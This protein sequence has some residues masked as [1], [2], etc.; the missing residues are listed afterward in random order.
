MF[1]KSKNLIIA[2]FILTASLIALSIY[3]HSDGSIKSISLLPDSASIKF[4]KKGCSLGDKFACNKLGNL[5]Y[6]KGRFE[7]AVEHYTQACQLE[8]GSGCN[9][10][11]YMLEKGKGID[12]DMNNALKLYKKACKYGDMEGCHNA[13]SIY[14][15]A[16]NYYKAKQYFKMSCGENKKHKRLGASCN[17]LGYM[18]AHGIYVAYSPQRAAK[19]Y[20]DACDNLGEVS[21]CNNLAYM[22][23]NGKGFK[24]STL[25][26]DMFYMKACELGDSSSCSKTHY[27]GGKIKKQ[28]SEDFRYAE[29]L[30]N[31]GRGTGCYQ[32]ALYYDN[33]LK[34][35]DMYMDYYKQACDKGYSPSCR[36]LGDLMDLKGE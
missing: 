29:R 10:L 4:Y 2:A 8:D 13:G 35:E 22:Y 19:Y 16:K 17:D 7:D 6:K 3:K 36:Y 14:Y 26:A 34:D 27:H 31:S 9:N 21:S 18:Y 24:K 15:R 25:Q 5:V 20:R 28:D 30:C 11:G 12:Q 32:L 1:K 23:E 33:I